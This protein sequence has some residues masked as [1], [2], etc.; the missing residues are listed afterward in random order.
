M[1]KIHQVSYTVAI[2]YAELAQSLLIAYSPMGFEEKVLPDGDVVFILYAELEEEDVLWHK[3]ITELLEQQ[4]HACVE[5]TISNS[6]SWIDIW[7]QTCT[8][9]SSGK[10]YVVPEW[11]DDK[12]P[13]NM[14]T[15]YI[16]PRMAFGTGH[17]AS[18][19]L[20]LKALSSSYI[21]EYI[22][23]GIFADIGTGSGILSI[24]SALLGMTGH[25]VDI[26]PIAIENAQENAI[27]NNV[28]NALSFYVGDIMALPLNQSYRLI[29][30]NII[31]EVLHPLSSS[32]ANHIEEKGIC[33][34]SGILANQMNAIITQYESDGF[35]CKHEER[36]GDWSMCILEYQG[37]N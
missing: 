9:V 12:I 19:A 16:T 7:K 22:L 31:S 30:A 32:I 17:H 20:C 24:A 18:T 28:Y 27:Y 8:P 14:H 36:E 10:F 23:K 29:M 34:L 33:I 25:A 5:Y 35:T 4:C 26:D 21:N 37:K 6:V 15:I 13:P 3:S 11:Y 1:N 2:E